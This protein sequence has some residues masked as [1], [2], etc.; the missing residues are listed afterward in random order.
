VDVR[1][2]V[3]NGDQVLL[4]QEASDGLWTLPGGYADVGLSPAE[5]VV[6]EVLE[7]ASLLVEV[8][9]LYSVRH[10]AK[11]HYE[12]DARDFYKLFF[13]CEPVGGPDVRP[14]SETRD[15]QFFALAELPSLSTGRVIREDI[16]MAFESRRSSLGL[17]W[18]D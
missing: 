9:S 4:V 7:E 17:T 18:C 1:A 8:R 16:E 13:I 14:G 2:A 12:A 10:K 15:V 3:F 11:H 5:N 6:K